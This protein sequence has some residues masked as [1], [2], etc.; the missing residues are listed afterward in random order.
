MS[1][2]SVYNCWKIR[3]SYQDYVSIS[4]NSGKKIQKGIKNIFIA[5]V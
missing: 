2:V 1:N 5:I 4:Y 3:E